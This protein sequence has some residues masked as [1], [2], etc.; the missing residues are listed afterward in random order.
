MFNFDQ[1]F[2]DQVQFALEEAKYKK[3][4]AGDQKNVQLA[5]N[6]TASIIHRDDKKIV[7]WFTRELRFMP[8]CL[9][10]ITVSFET[11][12]TI[13][14]NSLINDET[15]DMIISQV[16]KEKVAFVGTIY[17]RISLLIAQ[18]T[19]AIGNPPLFT[20]PSYQSNNPM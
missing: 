18:M 3:I 8:S 1:A 20:P 5:T 17:S 12:W 11:I 2:S 6:D 14:D 4:D 10:D 15:D 16:L 19:S 7:I 13:K 9:F